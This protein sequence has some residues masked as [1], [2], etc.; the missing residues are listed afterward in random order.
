MT[1]KPHPLS[2]RQPLVLKSGPGGP[3]PS[4]PSAPDAPLPIARRFVDTVAAAEYLCMSPRTLEKYRVHGGGPP[5]RRFGGRV[6]YAIEDLDRWADGQPVLRS[7][8]DT[9]R[10]IVR[11]GPADAVDSSIS[12]RR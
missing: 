9:G 7:T 6:V 8:S 10:R 12:E 11:S 1:K 4:A 5:F 2:L 3:S